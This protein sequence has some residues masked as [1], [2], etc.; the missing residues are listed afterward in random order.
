MK[1]RV[2]FSV[3][4]LFS[5]FLIGFVF[6]S[7]EVGETDY[8]INSVYGPGADLIGWVNMSFS[9]EPSDSVFEDSQGNSIQLI[10]LLKTTSLLSGTDYICNPLD[11]GTKYSKGD[12]ITDKFILNAGEEKVIG[13]EFNGDIQDIDSVGFNITSDAQSSCS[14][15]LKI[16]FFADGEVETGNTESGDESCSATRTYG[17]FN[18]SKNTESFIV[19]E[20]STMQCQRIELPEGA[21][22]ELGA[23]LNKQNE[24]KPTQIA[25]YDLNLIHEL[26]KCELS[27]SG[28]GEQTC[29]VDFLVTNPQEYYIC[30]F[31]D[32]NDGDGKT[33]LLGYEDSDGCG[34][35]GSKGYAPQ[36]AYSYRIFAQAR[37]FA[38]MSSINI[39]DDTLY[40]NGLGNEFLNYIID[41]YQGNCTSGCIV[42]I[43][44]ISNATQNISINHIDGSYSTSGPSKPIDK[45][46]SISSSPATISSD[47][48]KISLDKGNFTLSSDYGK[49]D[50]SLNFKGDEIINE[51]INITKVPE[52][53]KLTPLVAFNGFPIGFTV[54]VKAVNN[55]PI[56]KYIWEFENANAENTTANKNSHTFSSIGKFPVKISV[57]DSKGKIGTKIFE[58]DVQSYAGL[59]DKTLSDLN[60]KLDSLETGIQ[61]FDS[62]E[63]AG[64]EKVLN[65]NSTRSELSNIQAKWANAS[66]DNELKSIVNEILSISVPDSINKVD[67]NLLSY[68]P[69]ATYVE[70][71]AVK[72]KFGGNYSLADT[73]E[74]VNGILMW[75]TENL[76]TKIK[77]TKIQA[78]Y[79]EN[80]NNILSMFELQVTKTGGDS[81]FVF[82]RNLENLGFGGNYGQSNLTSY[83]AIPLDSATKTIKFYTTQDIGITDLP[84]FISPALEDI[85]VIGQVTQAEVNQKRMLIFGLILLFLIILGIIIYIIMQNW[86]KTKYENYLFK[87]RNNLFNLINFID[88]Q[89][90]KGVKDKEIMRKLKANKWKL[91]QIS[92]AMKKYAG[93]RTGMLE[94]PINKAVKKFSKEQQKT[95]QEKDIQQN[96][97]G[98]IKK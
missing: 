97:K 76:N 35:Y 14:N 2:I 65:I 90:K 33:I 84:V 5:V 96:K 13:F 58:V 10:N 17:C 11:C 40:E 80:M 20:F 28:E 8:S 42:P 85:Q 52:I 26:A 61:G 74:Y 73:S 18:E 44:L 88:T 31:N 32:K 64:I 27:Q 68:Y 77:Q 3:L 19:E 93:K 66:G 50:Y 30:V 43:K 60:N 34:I 1:K 22:F 15:Q 72:E 21:G 62:F 48:I 9:E 49:K 7:Y 75:N 78:N 95:T 45:I 92:Y 37:K 79:S 46:Y 55:T 83:T 16:D 87:D 4:V 38:S 70:L 69:K 36:E 6:A 56:I 81:A 59:Y 39:E 63:K 53:K 89:K 82:I 91:E 23:Y 25:I 86:Y 41:N 57:V 94:I 24:A 98:F 47:Y 29:N 67:T 54:D 71:S 12:E 51:E